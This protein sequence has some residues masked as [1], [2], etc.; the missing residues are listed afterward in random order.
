MRCIAVECASL[1]N[2]LGMCTHILSAISCVC[3]SRVRFVFKQ[4]FS[5]QKSFM[6]S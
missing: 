6:F 4:F 3:V 2:M 5:V 1:N